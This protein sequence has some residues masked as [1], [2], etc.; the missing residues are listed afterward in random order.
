DAVGAERRA[1]AGIESRLCGG[2]NGPADPDVVRRTGPGH[3]RTGAICSRG[4]S[5]AALTASRWGVP[6]LGVRRWHQFVSCR[7]APET[8]APSLTSGSGDGLN[9]ETV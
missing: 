5:R 8:S 7:L 6:N 3:R 2:G 1:L 4:V 9:G